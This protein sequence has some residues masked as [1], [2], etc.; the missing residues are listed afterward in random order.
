MIEF[1]R[2]IMEFIHAVRVGA[3]DSLK[4]AELAII[5]NKYEILSG[6]M[7]RANE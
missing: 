6:I 5:A 1:V 4:W 7:K 2:I 3:K